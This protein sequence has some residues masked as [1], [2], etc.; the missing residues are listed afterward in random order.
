MCKE[1]GAF[2]HVLVSTD[3]GEWSSSVEESLLPVVHLT[4]FL[5]CTFC[6]CLVLR[7]TQKVHFTTRA[8]R[9]NFLHQRWGDAGNV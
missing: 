1:E 4:N 2:L 5:P 3:V 8:Q 9:R 6:P 7:Y